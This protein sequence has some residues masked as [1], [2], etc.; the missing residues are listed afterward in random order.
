M[1]EQ[2]YF[3]TYEAI[4]DIRQASLWYENQKLNLGEEFQ[5]KFSNQFT[6]FANH[7]YLI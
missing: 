2:L 6:Q 5:T 3:L 7:P 1:I 4:E